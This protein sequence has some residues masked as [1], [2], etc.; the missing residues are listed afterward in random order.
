MGKNAFFWSKTLKRPSPSDLHLHPFAIAI[1]VNCFGRGLVG[2][3][4]SA[5]GIR[6]ALAG[7]VGRPSFCHLSW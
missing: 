2:A 6:Q 1:D 4:L 7:S 5:T 3:T